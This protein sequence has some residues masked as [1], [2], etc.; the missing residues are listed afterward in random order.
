MA[1]TLS[2]LI[3]L[4]LLLFPLSSSLPSSLP[5]PKLSPRDNTNTTTNGPQA[6]CHQA[7][8]RSLPQANLTTCDP[9]LSLLR[10]MQPYFEARLWGGP[11]P[12]ASSWLATGSTC[13]ISVAPLNFSGSMK[14]EFSF[15]TL[16]ATAMI[17]LVLCADPGYG[18]QME[19][20]V[21]DYGVNVQSIDP[22]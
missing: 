7:D 2:I 11:G 14:G 18:G 5:L 3:P 19:V 22:T 16:V 17:V 9:T 6:N 20:G 8:S 4:F 10:S 13:S 21:G 1:P 15:E 12:I